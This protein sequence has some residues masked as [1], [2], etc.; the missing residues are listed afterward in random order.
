MAQSRLVTLF[1][2]IFQFAEL[3]SGN[4]SKLHCF[5][6]KTCSHGVPVGM[7]VEHY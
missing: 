7:I 4:S 3:V 5:E 2:V 6:N 1:T